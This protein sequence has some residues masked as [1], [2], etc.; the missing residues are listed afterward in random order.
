[1]SAYMLMWAAVAVLGQNGPV[2]SL[3][4]GDLQ[5]ALLSEAERSSAIAAAAGNRYDPHV[6]TVL[7]PGMTAGD[8][9]LLARSGLRT[10]NSL[11]GDA[12][13]ASID[14]QAADHAADLAQSVQWLVPMAPQWKLHPTQ[15]PS[16]WRP[17][18]S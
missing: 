2:I 7:T 9:Q 13:I 5:I 15:S 10:L 6:L 17:S 3:Q 11:G 1:M 16:T 18:H 4:S 14:S 12:W 8:R